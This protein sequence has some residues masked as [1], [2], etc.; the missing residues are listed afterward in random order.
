MKASQL[1]CPVVVTCRA[2]DSL[3]SAIGKMWDHDIGCLPV[4]DE[5]NHVVGML[6]DRDVGMAAYTQGR[7]LRDIRVDSAMARVVFSAPSTDRVED[8]EVVMRK[9]KVHRVPVVDPDHRL[10]GVIST[11]DL[12]REAARQLRL[13]HPEVAEDEFVS[14]LACI[15]HPRVKAPPFPAAA[16]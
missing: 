5:D 10:V 9:H 16:E 12:A 4:V 11:N 8:V 13:K 3:E 1:M 15:C 6:T 7:L 14:T 2:E